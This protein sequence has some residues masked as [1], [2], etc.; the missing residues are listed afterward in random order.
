MRLL[1]AGGRS[2]C[3][4]AGERIVPAVRA[5]GER[6]VAARGRDA[7][8]VGGAGA[9]RRGRRRGGGGRVQ[10]AR[11][12]GGAAR[13]RRRRRAD[14]V[15][16][17]PSRRVLSATARPCSRRG[18]SGRCAARSLRQASSA[19]ALAGL[20][21]PRR[22]GDDATRARA[23]AGD[24]GRDQRG[25][26]G[27]AAGGAAR[28]ELRLLRRPDRAGAGAARGD[29]LDRRRGGRRRADVPAL[30]PHHGRRTR[31][32]GQRVRADRFRRPS[33]RALHR[34][35]AD[36][37]AGGARPA[38]S[39]PGPGRARVE[40]AWGG[41]IDVSADHLPFFGT[42][43]GT[44]RPLRPRLL[45]PRRR[46]ELARRPD[47]RVACARA[48]RR[49]DGAPARRPGASR[50]SRRSRSSASAAGSCAPRSWPASRPRRR[51]AARRCSPGP[52]H[53]CRGCW[54]C[55]SAPADAGGKIAAAAAVLWVHD[56]EGGRR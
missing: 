11:G 20:A 53:P 12:A 33:R 42:V 22:R 56:H 38:A 48:G 7:D 6:R 50:R 51:R 47:P 29:R 43:P 23:G 41:P 55:S 39:A 13:P 5:L 14:P 1:G 27:L 28:D 36:G 30:L 37:C 46:A 49:V 25:R 54:A 19:R 16:G 2:S 24:R 35:R 3:A 18:S 26:D 52:A 32:H 21:D 34:R 9:G 45:R 8:G 15:A 10:S 31:A 17:L 44:S 40:R 4:R